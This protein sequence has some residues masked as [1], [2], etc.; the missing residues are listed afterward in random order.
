MVSRESDADVI[1]VGGGVAGLGLACA[2]ARQELRVILLERRKHTGGIHRGDSLLP[3]ATYWLGRWGIH[4]AL[5]K[6]GAQPIAQMEIYHPRFGRVY[7]APIARPE[8]KNPYLVLPHARIE[9]V[10]QDQ[11]LASG[12]VELVRPAKALDLIKDPRTANVCGV[13][14]EKNGSMHQVRAR[15]VVGADGY[16]S[17]VRSRLGLAARVRHY[18]HAY[19]GLEA[20]RPAEYQPALS[21]HLHPEGGLLLMPRIDRVGI[22]LLVDARANSYWMSIPEER[23]LEHLVARAPMLKGMRLFRR[24]A[25]VYKLLRYHLSRYHEAGAA[26]IGDAI[27]CTNPTA[28]QGM[29]MGLTDAGRLVEQVG[30]ALRQGVS[31]LQPHLQAYQAACWSGNQ[32]L[33]RTSHLLSLIYALRGRSWTLLKLGVLRMLGT[34]SGATLVRPIISSFLK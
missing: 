30:P 8:N 26:L 31:D 21:V 2:L 9:S 33:F 6:A 16:R 14:F 5:M 28:G 12:Y 1:I 13:E 18:G 17:L 32:K 19:L 25:H 11:A 15:L 34:A 20:E 22:G 27:H 4:E 29:A 7:R 10:L 3:K 24:G 23:L